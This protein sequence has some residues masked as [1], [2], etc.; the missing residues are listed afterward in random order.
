MSSAPMPPGQG[1]AAAAAAATTMAAE[2]TEG[3]RPISIEELCFTTAMSCYEGW[4][5]LDPAIGPRTMAMVTKFFSRTLEKTHNLKDVRETLSSS[6]E[7]WIWLTKD[8][9]AAIPSLTTRSIGP[10][11]TLNDPEKGATTQESTA[12]I[13][14]NYTSLKEDLQLLIKLMH[15]ARNLLVVPEP[16]VA[17]DLCAAAQFDQ[18]L[19]QTI[20]LCVNVT[21]KAYDGDI[22]EEG[23]RLRLGEITELY[24]K[25]LVTC[26]Q[27]AHNWIAKNDRNKT[28]FWSTV[29][30]DDETAGE[31]EEANAGAGD[32]RP[33][34]AKIEVQN[35][36]ERNSRVCDKARQLLIQYEETLASRGFLPGNLSPISPLSW[37]WLPEGTIRT[38]AGDEEDDAKIIPHWKEDEPDKFEQD[39]AYGRVSREVDTWWLKVRDPNYDGWAVPMPLVEFAKQR[40]ENCKANLVNRYAHSYRTDEREGSVHSTEAPVPPDVAAEEEHEDGRAYSQDYNDDMIEEE[41][42]DDDDSYGE[43]PMSGLLTEVPNILDPKQIEALHM[44]V[45]SCILDNAGL[46]LTRAGENLQKTRCRMFL[47]LECGRSLLRE[48]LVFIA[49][50][51][52]NEQS[53]I[54]QLT[55]QI[56]EAIHHSA[57]IPYAWQSLR[58]PKDIISPAQTVLLRLVN[59]MFRARNADPPSPDSKEHLRDVKL[60]HFL[61]IQ[62]RSRIVPECAALMHLQEQILKGKCDPADFPVDTWDMER[63]KDGLEQ[64]LEL[65]TTVNEVV[66]TRE[67]LIEWEAAYELLVL[68]GG[69]EAGVAKKPLVDL[70]NHSTNEQTPD[71]SPSETPI[72][73]QRRD[74][75]DSQHP[76][77]PPPPPPPLQDPAHKFPWSD[78]KGKILHILAGLL[79]P[80]PGQSS[81]GNPTVQAQILHHQGIV[82]LLNC[83]VYDDHNRYA[84]ER[85]Q[86]C[87][88]WLMDGS[89]AANNFLRELVAMTPPPELRPQSSAPA[90]GGQLSPAPAPT[91]S[92]RID[93]IGGEVKVQLR[94]PSGA[95]GGS[96][97]NGSTVS[98]LANKAGSLALPSL[99]SSTAALLVD[100]L[101]NTA[102]NNTLPPIQSSPAQPS[103]TTQEARNRSAELLRDII[104]LADEAARLAMGRRI[105]A[106]ETEDEDFM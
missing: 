83:C 52:K 79:Q 17:Q 56:V 61:F 38:R 37:N 65:L 98:R 105:D 87:L 91:T 68:L 55:T 9:A 47:A 94:S 48:I 95:G 13:T 42:V 67:Y 88:K 103:T 100:D 5:K 23:A 106:D 26:L 21:S 57:L 69:L 20:I 86:I 2:A 84:R 81:P 3:R 101:R 39:R 97:N 4:L 60:L 40:T 78:I 75:E 19:Y 49:V 36:I 99:A 32:F 22:L 41:D 14:K 85:V 15:I 35:W 11:A 7:I 102:S 76:P 33:E 51:E 28:S 29:L 71:P 62:F 82:S 72:N 50:W 16:E 24:K 70:A 1:S 59:N 53:L 64:F 63:A 27:Q 96:G 66:E 6:V 44:I 30:F 54:F 45:K 8:F 93:G 90:A 92:L 80:P 18:M 10:L 34:V 31:E 89:D 73:N 77:P 74:D 46:A 104:T 58:I 12:L 25:L 43:G